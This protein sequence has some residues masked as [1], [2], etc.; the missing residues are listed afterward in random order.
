VDILP[1]FSDNITTIDFGTKGPPM[2]MRLYEPPPNNWQ[3][4]SPMHPANG[5]PAGL[6]AVSLTSRKSVSV[7][8]HTQHN[9]CVLF[10]S[11][12]KTKL[13]DRTSIRVTPRPA[14]LCVCGRTLLQAWSPPMTV[15]SKCSFYSGVM[16]TMKLVS[17]SQALATRD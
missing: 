17:R 5:L 7:R 3:L 10:T 6:S 16:T 12:L 15:K 4:V 14:G 2:A 9:D 11:L 13:S 8:L 1:N